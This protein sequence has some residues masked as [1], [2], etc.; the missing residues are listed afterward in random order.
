MI[1][2]RKHIKG[3]MSDFNQYMAKVLDYLKNSVLQI[4]WKNIA[5]DAV[6]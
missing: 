4:N 2:I 1:S 5:S 6:K 3:L